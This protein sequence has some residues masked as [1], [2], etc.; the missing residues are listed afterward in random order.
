MSLLL[1]NKA[2]EINFNKI[3]WFYETTDKVITGAKNIIT[4][5]QDLTLV[6]DEILEILKLLKA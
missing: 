5:S 1:N 2:A 3:I 6:E 4:N